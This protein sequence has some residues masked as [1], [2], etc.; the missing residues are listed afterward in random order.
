MNHYEPKKS[1]GNQV[2]FTVRTTV[3]KDKKI[4]EIMEAFDRSRNYII[5]AAIEDYLEKYKNIIEG[6]Q[7]IEAGRVYDF[8]TA[9]NSLKKDL[10][11]KIANTDDNHRKSS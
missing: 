2:A 11:T 5:N 8:D 1:T 4:K 10:L 6:L 7:D 9:V 3:E